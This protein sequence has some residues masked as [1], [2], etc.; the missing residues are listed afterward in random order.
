MW[1]TSG[2]LMTLNSLWCIPLH[3]LPPCF[4]FPSCQVQI[5]R[6]ADLLYTKELQLTALT[7]LLSQVSG[8][9]RPDQESSFREA[10]RAQLLCLY[11]ARVSPDLHY[12]AGVGLI[13]AHYGCVCT[14]YRIFREKKKFILILASS[15]FTSLHTLLSGL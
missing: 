11:S 8:A 13:S 3:Q 6:E 10:H 15:S 2:Q 7:T 12:R 9:T 1:A 4:Y 5:S 14:G